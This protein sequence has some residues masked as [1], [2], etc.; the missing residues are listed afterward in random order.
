MNNWMLGVGIYF[1]IG[2]VVCLTVTI[3]HWLS[4]RRESDFARDLLKTLNPRRTDFLYRVL[5][6]F[7]FPVLAFCAIWLVWP[8]AIGLRIKE[9]ID[10]KKA[11]TQIKADKEEKVFVVQEAEL[12]KQ[13]TIA[14][15][16]QQNIIVDPMEAVPQV[17]FGYLNARWISFRDSLAPHETLWEYA[18]SRTEVPE[19]QSVW[20][21]A[22]KTDGRVDRFMTVGWKVIKP[23]QS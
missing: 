1:A 22:V 20:G 10:K 14:E 12:I 21:Y 19:M 11:T 2:L 9:I 17:P 6:D 16:E 3:S 8:L 4:K 15:V 23:K 7:I 18:S 5:D 13:V